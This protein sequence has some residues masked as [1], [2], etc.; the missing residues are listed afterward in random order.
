MFTV[1]M[2]YRFNANLGRLFFRIE[3]SYANSEWV[4]IAYPV[5]TWPIKVKNSSTQ[6]F[7][8]IIEPL[9]GWWVLHTLRSK[10]ERVAYILLTYT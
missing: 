1:P 3:L 10:P 2:S 9:Y 5:G 6:Y 8:R 7:I 4:N